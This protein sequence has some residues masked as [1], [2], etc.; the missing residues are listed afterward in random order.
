MLV[1]RAV[2]EGNQDLKFYLE[3]GLEDKFKEMRKR[4]IPRVVD[5]NE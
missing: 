3:H 2:S 1:R 4:V 5:T